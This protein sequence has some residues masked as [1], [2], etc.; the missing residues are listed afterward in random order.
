[1]INAF[2]QVAPNVKLAAIIVDDNASGVAAAGSAVA[3]VSTPT[4]GTFYLTV[5]SY[6]KNRYAITT[7]TSSTA[8]TIGDDIEAAINADGNSPVTA[9]NSSG[10]VTLTAKNDGTEGN[11]IGLKVESLPS[12]V[13]VALTALTSGATDPSLT[14]V[15]TKIDALRYDIISPV[16]FL[17]DIKTH[18]EAKFNV[19]N[20]IL[21]GVGFVCKTA[22]YAN[23]QTALAPATLASKVITYINNKIVAD[24]DWKGGSVLELDYVI[25]SYI[26]AIRA[27]RFKSNASISSYMQSPNNRG[28]AFLAGIP[29][30]NMKLVDLAILPA[31]K[32]FTLTEIQ[33]LAELGGSTLSP[34]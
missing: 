17:A 32:A 6:T 2:K 7:T 27:L 16:A 12:G 3:S 4:A 19:T 8:T 22:T 24:A 26:A 21:D 14:G 20:N 5:G 33:G 9:S 34:R 18:L 13:A 11:N 15:L 28:G 1:M 29:Y 10:T 31:E 23:A 25:A 30:H